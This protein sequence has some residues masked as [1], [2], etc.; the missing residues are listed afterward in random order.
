MSFEAIATNRRT[1]DILEDYDLSLYAFRDDDST[2][3]P[4][5]VDHPD[6]LFLGLDYFGFSSFPESNF[7]IATLAGGERDYRGAELIFRKRRSGH[8]QALASYTFGAA[9]G[10][11][12]SDSHAIAQGD[13]V[14]LDPRAPA[15][16]GDMPGSIR[17]LFKLAASYEWDFGLELGGTF[18]WNSGTLATRRLGAD[19]PA[20]V[21]ASEAFEFAGYTTRWLAPDAVGSLQNPAGGQLDL[22]V[23]YTKRLG[24]ARG[25]AFLDAFNVLNGQG[26]TRN[27]D[28]VAGSGTIA[29]GEAMEFR[30]PRRFYLGARVSF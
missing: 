10:N 4:G 27:E 11:A 23:R 30:A 17:H 29:F 15:R 20:R 16:H 12:E 7:V 25:E 21:P 1:R 13:L 26:A 5:P 24:Q 3:Y 8:W 6:S 9:D 14:W 2:S 19:V 28:R 22:R 18:R